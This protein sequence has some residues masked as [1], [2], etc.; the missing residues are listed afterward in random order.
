MYSNQK[1]SKLIVFATKFPYMH[2]LI[3]YF[4]FRF[5]AAR[6]MTDLLASILIAKCRRGV[7]EPLGT[8]LRVEK[9]AVRL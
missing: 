1:I 5:K 3:F 9:N 7:L 8:V 2:K 4:L 6:L